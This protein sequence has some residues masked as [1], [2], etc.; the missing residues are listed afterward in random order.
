ME[1]ETVSDTVDWDPT[2]LGTGI[3]AWIAFDKVKL[4]SSS[5]RTCCNA[6]VDDTSSRN[7]VEDSPVD[8]LPGMHVPYVWVRV[9]SDV[10]G[11]RTQRVRGTPPIV[12][13]R[14]AVLLPDGT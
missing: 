1:F 13:S 7:A 10:L 9:L 3:T 8:K 5:V 11:Q 4:D 14:S 12:K 6:D 2:E